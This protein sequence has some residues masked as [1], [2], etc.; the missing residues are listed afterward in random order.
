MGDHAGAGA[1]GGAGV[2]A[3]AR[4]SAAGASVDDD[5]VDAS[6]LGARTGGDEHPPARAAANASMT[7]R[8]P[9]MRTTLA[10]ASGGLKEKRGN[11]AS[12]LQ[13][14]AFLLGLAGE[15]FQRVLVAERQAD[16][17]PEQKARAHGQADEERRHLFA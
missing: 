2:V 16:A 6:A 5:D 11:G 7:F 1:D 14:G 17:E 4:A 12:A 15:L 3:D 10:R 9:R 13:C 8:S